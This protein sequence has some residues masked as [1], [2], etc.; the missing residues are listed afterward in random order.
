MHAG[1]SIKSTWCAG[2]CTKELGQANSSPRPCRQWGGWSELKGHAVP[3][4]ISGPWVTTSVTG[5][6]ITGAPRVPSPDLW[7]LETSPT[8]RAG[9]LPRRSQNPRTQMQRLCAELWGWAAQSLL[10]SSSPSA[11][12][13]GAHAGYYP[14]WPLR[15]GGTG[16]CPRRKARD[17]GERHTEPRRKTPREVLRSVL[18]TRGDKWIREADATLNLA[19]SGSDSDTEAHRPSGAAS[20]RVPQG[21]AQVPRLPL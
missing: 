6:W 11:E 12:P 2:S 5:N 13:L 17:K 16:T 4:L 20:A 7:T 8:K 10:L 19:C 1:L 9:P 14:T 18:G 15:C 3:L 21:D